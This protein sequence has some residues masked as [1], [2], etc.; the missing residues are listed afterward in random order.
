MS[1]A[2][3]QI[4]EIQQHLADGFITESEIDEVLEDWTK[5]DEI[6]NI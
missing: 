4:D 2:L 6:L 3:H 1:L 5:L